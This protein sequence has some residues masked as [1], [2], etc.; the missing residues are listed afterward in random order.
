MSNKTICEEKFNQF[1]EIGKNISSIKTSTKKK[2]AMLEIA[3]TDELANK[4]MQ[5]YGDK[6]DIAN[7]YLCWK[8]LGIQQKANNETS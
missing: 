6:C 3:I 2:S 7:M 1:L 4:L 8:D 5:C